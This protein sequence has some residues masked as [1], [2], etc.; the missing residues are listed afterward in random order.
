MSTSDELCWQTLTQ[1]GEMI[2]AGQV[3]SVDVTE[4]ML[5]RIERYDD[6]YHSYFTVMREHALQQARSADTVIATVAHSTTSSVVLCS[7][8]STAT[9]TASTAVPTE[10]VVPYSKSC[11]VRAASMY[12]EDCCSASFASLL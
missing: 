11:R 1:I 5:A 6:N 7:S 4:M 9:T 8:A 2:R 3:S 12:S 10:E